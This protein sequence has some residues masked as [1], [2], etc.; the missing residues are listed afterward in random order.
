MRGGKS[1]FPTTWLSATL[2]HTLFLSSVLRQRNAF[3][4]RYSP[5]SKQAGMGRMWAELG[6]HST[7]PRDQSSLTA[8]TN[9]EEK[10]DNEGLSLLRCL[11]RLLPGQRLPS[12]PAWP[13]TTHGRCLA[14]LPSADRS[15][16]WSQYQ[17]WCTA[18]CTGICRYPFNSDCC[19]ASISQWLL[20]CDFK[21]FLMQSPRKGIARNA[22]SSP[23]FAV[24]SS[25]S[26]LFFRNLSYT[27]FKKYLSRNFKHSDFDNYQKH[28][29]SYVFKNLRILVLQVFLLNSSHQWK[30][31]QTIIFF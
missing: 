16:C 23:A 14:S 8:T 29:K 31:T 18:E 22:S 2:R 28:F 10:D 7:P 3:L 6:I 13:R 30:P 24:E 20:V 5:A 11:P 26:A 21:H 4:A 12:P 15:P 9:A 19:L 17:R 27:N 25:P 1:I